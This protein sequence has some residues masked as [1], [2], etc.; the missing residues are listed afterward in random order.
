V[1]GGKSMDISALSSLASSATAANAIEVAVLSK[2]MDSFED[3]GND[4]VQMME[5]SVTPNL[6]QNIDVRI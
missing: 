5:S 2:T 1:K 6:G 4:M 3:L